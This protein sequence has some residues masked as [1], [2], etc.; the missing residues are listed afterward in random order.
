MH[1]QNQEFQNVCMG[2]WIHS[3][4]SS[5]YLEFLNTILVLPFKCDLNL[6]VLSVFVKRVVVMDTPSIFNPHET[7]RWVWKNGL[8]SFFHPSFLF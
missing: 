5:V 4:E 1:I 7:L 8:S 3:S 6:A 2:K